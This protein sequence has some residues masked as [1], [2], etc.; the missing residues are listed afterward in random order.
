MNPFQKY[1][2]EEDCALQAI[3]KWL[4]YTYPMAVWCHPVN[5]GKRTPWERWRAQELGIRAGLPDLLLFERRGNYSG[6]AIELKAGTNKATPSQQKWL[7][8]LTQCG[9][10]AIVAYGSEEAQKIIDKY[11]SGKT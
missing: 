2:K 3:V 1:L 10:V 6:L 7:N 4:Q 5:E 9:W 11:L 8:D